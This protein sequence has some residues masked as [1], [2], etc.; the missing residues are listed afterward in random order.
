MVEAV[1]VAVKKFSKS[2]F[3]TLKVK[4]LFYSGLIL[5]ELVETM[6]KD[7]LV[8]VVFCFSYPEAS[9]GASASKTTKK[10]KGKKKGKSQIS[11]F[12]EDSPSIFDDPLNATSK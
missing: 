6:R 10:A 11:I 3:C 8:N 12:D 4:T 5:V 1:F 7:D 2:V 9:E